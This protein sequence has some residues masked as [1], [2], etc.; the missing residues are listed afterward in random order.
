MAVVLKAMRGWK[1]STPHSLLDIGNSPDESHQD[2]SHGSD[3]L[4]WHSESR[5][6]HIQQAGTYECR[7]DTSRYTILQKIYVCKVEST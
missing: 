1:F 2:K 5:Y 6:Y 4:A 3:N 7:D